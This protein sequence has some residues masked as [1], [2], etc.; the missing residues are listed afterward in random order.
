MVQLVQQGSNQFVASA[1][2]GSI[3]KCFG[4]QI[5]RI[6][7]TGV[8][9]ADIKGLR[10]VV[11]RDVRGT[12]GWREGNFLLPCA[13]VRDLFL[14]SAIQ[15]AGVPRIVFASVIRQ[16]SV[17]PHDGEG[18]LNLSK[19]KGLFAPGGGVVDLGAALQSVLKFPAVLSNVVQ[20]ARQLGLLTAPEGLG[21][22]F[23]QCGSA[24]QM[25]LYRLHSLP[26]LRNVGKKDFRLGHDESP[27]IKSEIGLMYYHHLTT[28]RQQSTQKTKKLFLLFVD[29]FP[30]G[31][32]SP[33]S[34]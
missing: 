22:D 28:L 27:P 11:E 13:V 18:R 30:D 26:V 23:G 6:H 12:P 15:G 24:L 4:V 21:K 32:L 7:Q 3:H 31:A 19:L 25:L 10:E 5:V 1:R 33:T 9:H 29:M 17:V 8:E 16:S 34:G 20:L 2:E 14:L